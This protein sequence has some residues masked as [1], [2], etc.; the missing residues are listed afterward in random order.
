MIFLLIFC[1]VHGVCV[2]ND[3]TYFYK[4]IND[5]YTELGVAFK[6]EDIVSIMD[7]FKGLGYDKT[8][9]SELEL[10]K[11]ISSQTG[12]I[13]DPTYT[14]KAVRAMLTDKT[15]HDRKVLFIH[16][17]GLFSIYSKIDLMP[18]DMFDLKFF[19][20]KKPSFLLVYEH[21]HILHQYILLMICFF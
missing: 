6:A 16:T 1:R 2:C 14:L 15:F 20:S 19:Q 13:L 8:T 11:Q 12:V 5:L 10:M 9:P 21:P 3:S 7:G 18:K 17:G 4:V